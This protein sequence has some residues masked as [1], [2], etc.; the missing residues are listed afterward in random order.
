[1]LSLIPKYPE[2]RERVDN[3]SANGPSDIG[4]ASRSG[5]G[6]GPRQG[7]PT[8]PLPIAARQIVSD[9][10]SRLFTPKSVAI[11]GGGW[12]QNVVTQLRRAG[13]GGDIWPV[14]PTRADVGGVPAFADVNALP[15]APDCAFIGV[16]R[17][18]TLDVLA[19][20]KRAGCGGAICFASGFAEA[21]DTS[22]QTDLREAA[23]D[24]AV[25]G[26][27]CYGILNYFDNVALWPDQHGGVPVDRGVGIISQSSNIAINLTMSARGLPIGKVACVGNAAKIGAA[28]LAG[29]MINDPRITAIGFYLEGFGDAQ[30]FAAMAGAAQAAGKP[31]AAI[32]AGR[33]DAARA[34]AA[35]HTAALAGSG[36]VSS[37]FLRQCGVAEVDDLA[38]LIEALKIFHVTGG[39]AG[40]RI[41]TLSCSGGEAG[42][43]ADCAEGTGL[44]FPPHAPAQATQLSDL[45]GPLVTIANPLDYHTFIWGDEARMADVFGTVAAGG[46]DLTALVMDMPHAM[47]CDSSAWLPTL[48]AL[49]RADTAAPG[50]M[51]LLSTLS[52]G[53][54]E[55]VARDLLADGIVPLCGLRE[56]L[57]AIACA[58]RQMS[59]PWQ[60][61]PNLPDGP[62][63]LLSETE[64]KARLAAMGVPVPPQLATTPDLPGPFAVKGLGLAHKSEAGAVRLNIP[65]DGVDVAC[66]AIA[67]P[68]GHL[69]EQMVTDGIAELLL[70]VRRDPVC[71]AT[72]TLGRGGTQ[73]ELFADTVTLVLPV[74]TA[75]IDAALDRLVMAP[76]LHGF[77]GKPPADRGA[78]IACADTLAKAIATDNSIDEIEIN[79]LIVRPR[80][81]VAADVLMRIREQP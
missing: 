30:A 9:R 63:V 79:P 34:A 35:S 50:P 2:E 29:H 78:I 49:R 19:A 28:D 5:A 4:D 1:M 8:A 32:K 23:G 41:A 74:T 80:G 71:G 11:F 45:L 73:T 53:L 47:R 68:D 25:L 15:S 70:T 39:L 64:G 13:Y 55:D 38:T 26:P 44:A 77:R 42:L 22:L 61:L 36:T 65:R 17:Q 75:Q 69:V 6:G 14:H 51:A 72:L 33:T 62:T 52:D 46:F 10:L 76:L 43:I 31:L 21:G 57:A 54:A 67:A 20:L 3:E 18:A 37:A 27:N 16:N 24:M 48:A 40:N 7:A 56:S 58:Q 81:A 12:A 66:A 60:P 59:A